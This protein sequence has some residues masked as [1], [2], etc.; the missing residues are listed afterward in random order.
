VTEP[1]GVVAAAMS[2]VSAASFRCTS[3]GNCCRSLRVAITI[4][5]LA[6]LMIA[7]QLAP[8]ELVDWL[9]PEAVDMT[10]EPQSFVELDAGRRLLV[11]A[12]QGDAC[13]LLGDD[14]LCRAY[15]ARPRDCRAFPFDFGPPNPDGSGQRRLGLLPLVD[16]DF[17]TD[18]HND[19]AAL[20]VEDRARWDEL[21]QYQ[22]L[23]AKWNQRAWHRRR[24]HKAAGSAEQ[25]L[26]FALDAIGGSE[27]TAGRR[28][29]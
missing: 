28:A 16:C 21:A 27:A 1:D 20:A 26:A 9:A 11:L 13:R 12:R 15:A 8:S 4:R 7:T 23:V 25:F 29:P 3:C 24:L 2:E 14:N 17:A 6:R 22:A 19:E 18:G 10:G 5:D